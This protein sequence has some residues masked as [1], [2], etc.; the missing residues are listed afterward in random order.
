M[1]SKISSYE[2]LKQRGYITE[3]DLNKCRNFSRSKIE[4]MLCSKLPYI[5]SIAV[6]LISEKY[7]I[8]KEMCI[9]FC[10]MLKKEKKLYT[11]LEIS[12]VLQYS[13]EDNIEILT[14]YLGVIGTNQYKEVPDKKFMKKS[15]PLPRDI[16]ARIIAHMNI[17][18]LPSLIKVLQCNDETKI[19]EAIDAIGFLCFYNKEKFNEEETADIIFSCYKKFKD[20]DLIRWKLVRCFESFVSTNIITELQKIK[21]NDKCSIIRFEAERSLGK[22][23]GRYN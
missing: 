6:R 11:K 10:E 8:D 4:E 22:I 15:Y 1:N 3:D 18:V 23:N 12:S 9:K 20:N 17:K 21:S 19:S 14:D 16:M 7:E 13:C 5:R 2:S